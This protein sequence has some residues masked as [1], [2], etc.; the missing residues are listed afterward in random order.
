[1]KNVEIVQFEGTKLLVVTPD[2]KLSWSKHVDTTVAKMGRSLSITKR[3]SAFLT[4]LSTRQVL[5]GLFLSHL[6]YCAVVWSGAT[7]R[8]LGKYN[9]LRTGQHGWPLNVNRELALIICMS[10][11]QVEESDQITTC[12]CRKC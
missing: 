10:I 2:C 3:Y 8:D 9:W 1:M 5:Q 6:D 7:K 11:S 4:T 12:F